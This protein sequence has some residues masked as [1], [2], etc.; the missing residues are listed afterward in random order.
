MT[1]LYVAGGVLLGFFVGALIVGRILGGLLG[2]SLDAIMR[3]F[4]GS[5][6][7]RRK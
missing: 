1:Y 7:L 2:R 4:G 3:P 6:H 5:I